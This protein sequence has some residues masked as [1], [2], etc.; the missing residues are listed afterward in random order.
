MD[1]NKGVRSGLYA[2]CDISLIPLSS[3]SLFQKL[4]YMQILQNFWLTL[5]L[6]FTGLKSWISDLVSI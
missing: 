6:T 5:V 2:G 3:W 1:Q 4:A